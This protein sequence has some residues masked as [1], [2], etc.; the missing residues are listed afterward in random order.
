MHGMTAGG[1][2][3]VTAPTVIVTVGTLGDSGQAVAQMFIG[4][5]EGITP[6]GTDRTPIRHGMNV[7]TLGMD[8]TT[9]LMLDSAL[10]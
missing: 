6:T 9:V 7:F 2:G 1:V 10:R 3:K 4:P 8:T 5:A